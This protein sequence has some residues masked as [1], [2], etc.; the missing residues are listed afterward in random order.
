MWGPVA[1]L[2]L[3]AIGLG[4]Y[5]A[6]GGTFHHY[7]APEMP[8]PHHSSLVVWLS[9][10]VGFLGIALGWLVY[11]RRTMLQAHEAD[12]LE[13]VAPAVFTVLNRKWYIDEVYEATVIRGTLAAGRL[14][15]VVDKLVVDGLLHAI[16]WAAYGVS[17]FIRWVGDEFLINGGFDSGCEGVRNS[18]E[19]LAKLQSGRVQ[20]YIRVMS[21]GAMVL[22][23]IYWLV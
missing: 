2:S 16:A 4:W 6:K 22:L 8:T 1:V 17:Q 23:L 5:G 9:V 14:F 11:G 12:P 10:G 15:R 21:L 20:N 7:L 3:F 13:R 19:L 18:G